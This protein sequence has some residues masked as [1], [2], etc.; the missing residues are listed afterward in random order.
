LKGRGY[1]NEHDREL[2]R[3]R[4][5][6]AQRGYGGRWQQVR[7]L[8]LKEN[9]LCVIC[10]QEGRIKPAIVV[11]HIEPH[12]GNVTVFWDPSN[13]QGLCATHHNKKTMKG[14]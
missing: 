13:W 4:G 11:D 14:Q 6:A 5:T 8:H 7:L 10:K 2:D 1:C 3:S 9:P 12:R